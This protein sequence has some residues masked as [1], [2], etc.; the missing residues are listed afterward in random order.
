V[1]ATSELPDE[2]PDE[3]CE[4]ELAGAE[5]PEPELLCAGSALFLLPQAAR[6]NTIARARTIAKIFF[7]EKPPLK[8]TYR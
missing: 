5:L 1:P 8:I 7:I 3:A 4:P 2:L 6:V